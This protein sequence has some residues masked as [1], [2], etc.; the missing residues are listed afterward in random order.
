MDEDIKPGQI[1]DPKGEEAY[2]R[3][4]ADAGKMNP[5]RVPNAA[6]FENSPSATEYL[7]KRD[8]QLFSQRETSFDPEQR[9]RNPNFVPPPKDARRATQG[10]LSPIGSTSQSVVSSGSQAAAHPSMTATRNIKTEGQPGTPT[11]QPAD[12]TQRFADPQNYQGQAPAPAVM[13]PTF[14]PTGPGRMLR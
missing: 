13:E 8:R 9:L 14:G 5:P 12:V 3:C 11:M 1:E 4:F 10:S 7:R 2:Q 6:F